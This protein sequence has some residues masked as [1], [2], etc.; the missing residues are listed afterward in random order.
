LKEHHAIT[1]S[2]CLILKALSTSFKSLEGQFKGT[3]LAENIDASDVD[4][5]SF[6]TPTPHNFEFQ[7]ISHDKIREEIKQMK[8]AK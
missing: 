2:F 6:V 4:P 7:T 8:I 3:R 1:T 5:L